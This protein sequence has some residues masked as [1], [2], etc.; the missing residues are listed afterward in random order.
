VLYLFDL[1]YRDGYDLRGCSL[2]V[3]KKALEDV[4]Q[5]GTPVRFSEHLA[6]VGVAMR[7]RACEM[8]LE[9]I[10]CKRLDSVYRGGRGRAWLKVKCQGREEFVILGYTRPKGGRSGLGALQLGFYDP[11]GKLH[12]AGGCGSGFSDAVLRDLAKQLGALKTGRPAAL[13][14]TDEAPPAG[15]TWVTPSLVAEVQY[16]AWSGAGRLRHAVFLGL[17][18]DKSAVDVVREIPDPEARRHELG[19]ADAA[20]VVV[21]ARKPAP[22]TPGARVSGGAKQSVQDSMSAGVNITHPDRE[23][24]PGITKQALAAYWQK[25]APHALPGIAGRPLAFVRCPDGIDGQHF[26][27]KHASKGM[28]ASL[29]EGNFDGAPY[30]ALEDAAGLAACAQIAAIEVHAWGSTTGDAGR[31]DQLVFD[32]DPGEG[33]AWPAMIA[34]AHDI[35][36]RLEGAGLTA[37]AR[38]SGGGGL[39]LVV[40]LVPQADWD[41]ARAWCRAFAEAAARENPDKYVAS[42]QKA[43]R[44][45]KILIDWLRNGLGSTAA[46]SFSPRARPHAT[47]A[48]PL[49]WEEVTPKLDPQLL[50]IATVPGRLAKLKRDPWADFN[51]ARRTLPAEKGK[52]NG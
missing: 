4:P 8:G 18:Q 12:Y 34:A 7:V 51:A 21:T 41:T 31:P 36:K 3:R 44:R 14:L 24:W 25:V 28:P 1:L 38:T 43:K 48:T 50:T 45:G 10:I 39:H 15:V 6:G 46:A 27:Q 16:T 5:A 17:R 47:V 37:F 23:L 22:R 40:P 29:H 2:D 33:L 20:P 32:L 49:A 26:F 35:R 42:V 9:G 30:L 13:L 52:K 11:A 19:G